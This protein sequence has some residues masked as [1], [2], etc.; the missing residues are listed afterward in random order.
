MKTYS[1]PLEKTKKL[2]KNESV[3]TK[4]KKKALV[5]DGVQKA[6]FIAIIMLISGIGLLLAGGIFFFLAIPVFLFIPAI[7]YIVPILE[8]DFSIDDEEDFLRKIIEDLEG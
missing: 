2:E 6:Y 1:I 8:M 4:L 7:I 5:N 3:Q